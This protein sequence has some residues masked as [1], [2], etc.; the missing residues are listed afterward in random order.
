[1]DKSIFIIAF[2]CHPEKGSEPGMAWNYICN[3][4][5]GV[6]T[7]HVLTPE[8]ED[9]KEKIIQ[10]KPDNVCF[11]FIKL[12]PEPLKHKFP[13]NYFLYNRWHN[14]AS[15]FLSKFLDEN[16]IDVVHL[17]NTVGYRL[18]GKAHLVC[19]CKNVP[20]IWGPIDG[21]SQFPLIKAM[22]Y[23]TLKGIIYY[24]L[25][26]L[27]NYIQFNFSSC[28]KK[29]LYNSNVVIVA[30]NDMRE[31]LKKRHKIDAVVIKEVGTELVKLS[32]D[33]ECNNNKIVI[34]WSGQFIH[35]KGL[36]ILLDALSK[37]DKS[38]R[39]RFYLKVIGDGELKENWMKLSNSYNI[40][41]IQWLGWL[42]KKQAIYELSNSDLFIQTS[43]R[44]V[45]ST[46]I[47]ESMSYC[48]PVISSNLCG[49]KD[50]IND[51]VGWLYDISSS[52]NLKNILEHIA[53]DKSILQV[54]SERLK[55]YISDLT[56]A[57][58]TKLILDVY[59]STDD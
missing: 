58:N 4:A 27:A 59:K 49:M 13:F 24:I 57:S 1:M 40:E 31:L 25:Y 21:G 33:K 51:D 56:W 28:F 45:T 30:T 9:N 23:L 47:V 20:Y 55:D 53:Q 14:K 38:I 29:A 32:Q 16:E 15:E 48:V 10:L 26:N 37:L 3:I 50:I 7:L 2:S 5:K 43:F 36:P 17:I 6:D 35:R 41:N 44:E 8:H 42:D 54:K 19:K 11:H 52:D 22:K 34:S 18:Q 46:V 39:N 12:D